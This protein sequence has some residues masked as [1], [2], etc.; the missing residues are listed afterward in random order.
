MT[1]FYSLW[2]LYRQLKYVCI[3]GDIR[4]LS[5]AVVLEGAIPEGEERHDGRSPEFAPQADDA[6][7]CIVPTLKVHEELKGVVV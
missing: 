1:D 3:S 5:A 6:E 2:Y 4:N 7:Q